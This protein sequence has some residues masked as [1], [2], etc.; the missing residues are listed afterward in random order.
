MSE[1]QRYPNDFDGYYAGSVDQNHAEDMVGFLYTFLINRATPIASKLC[2][3]AQYVYAK[4][5]GLD[6]LVDGSIENPKSCSFDPLVD[7]PACPGDIDASNCWT[8]AQRTAVKKLYDGPK[9]SWGQPI[10]P[11]Y[12]FGSEVC[13][14]PNDPATSGWNRMAN[15]FGS[16]IAGPQIKELFLRISGA[17]DYTK[18][19]FDTDTFKVFA[20]MTADA[21]R[22]DTPDLWNMK[23][24]GGKIIIAHGLGGDHWPYAANSDYYYDQVVEYMGAEN[25][26]QFV[27][28]YTM[29]G[30]GHCNAAN[31][32]CSYVDWFTPLQNWVEKGI[33]PGALIGTRAQTA[34]LTARSRPLCPY[35]EVA[36]YLGTGSIDEAANF[37]C[38]EIIPAARVRIIP[39]SVNLSRTGKF[40]A[41]VRLPDG[42][43]A[44]D[45]EIRAVV[46][47]GAPAVRVNAIGQT[48]IAWFNMEDLINPITPGE[49]VTFR[50]SVI[51]QYNGQTVAFEGSDTVK[52]M[53]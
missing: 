50:V 32:G 7:L 10:G 2:L 18:F 42:Y 15:T 1:A 4:C 39:A 30:I 3:Q 29:P 43:R 26:E 25:V 34:Y 23:K 49:E 13:S 52:V 11:R 31:V 9:T 44:R 38:A 35:P 37:T 41:L 28:F 6:G 36:R 12:P 22:V 5:D 48:G 24:Q 45:L 46:C 16:A 20:S 19:N 8:L 40:A 21:M 14:N 27:R 17:W 33:E 47:E 53:E 51:A